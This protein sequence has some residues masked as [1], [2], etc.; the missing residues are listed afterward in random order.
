A[1]AG[2]ATVLVLLG[3]HL[4]QHDRIDD[5]QVR[6]VG[7]KRK[8]HAVAVEG[9]VRGG[10]QVVFDVARAIDVFGLGRAALEFVE[11]GAMRLAHDVGED[12]EAP[13]VRHADD[14]LLDPELATALDD[15]LQ[16]RHHRLGAVE[17]KTLRAGIF[18]IGELLERFC[19]DEL[20]ED[21]LLALVGEDDVLVLAFDALLDPRLLRR[22]GDVHEL[23][24]DV[25]AIGA[26]K[27]FEDF[28]HGGH[29]EAQHLV[30]EDRPVEIGLRKAVGFRPQLLVDLPLA[31]AQ[32]IEIGGEMA[33]D[34]IGADQHEGA[35]A[36]LGGAQRG[37]GAQLNAAGGS[38][39]LEPPPD[40]LLSLSPI[41]GQCTKE[42]AIALLSDGIARLS[43]RRAAMFV[44]A[45][46]T[47]LLFLQAGEEMAPFIADRTGV[48]L[49]L[50][51]HLLDVGGIGTLQK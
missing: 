15:L 31:E 2:F 48:A 44:A 25:S 33:H 51:L 23:D 22:R 11:D 38:A 12:I 36:V 5:L 50:R 3:A 17:A 1:L 26:A 21:R 39:R 47:G 30:D 16:R 18:H 29:L 37:G 35:D 10:A 43:P 28:A 4:A 27:D 6:G 40:V 41:T 34:A 24:A 14:D 42:L 9:A 49:V 19:L 46:A 13:A 8:M 7:R 20:V 32:G 45:V